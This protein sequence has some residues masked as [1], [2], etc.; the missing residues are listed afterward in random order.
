MAKFIKVT[1]QKWPDVAKKPEIVKLKTIERIHAWPCSWGGQ[2]WINLQG[3]GY[4]LAIE[5]PEEIYALIQAAQTLT[6]EAQN[7]QVY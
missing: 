6:A 2:S 4:I 1:S 3:G 5:T 7:G